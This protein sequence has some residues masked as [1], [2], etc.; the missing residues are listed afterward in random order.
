[1][2]ETTGLDDDAP[3]PEERYAGF[4]IRALALLI[5]TALVWSIT[6]PILLTVHGQAYWES[7]SFFYSPLDFLLSWVLPTIVEITFWH[8]R[9]ASPGKM[10]VGVRI[11]DA[12]AGG[13]LTLAQCVGRYFAMYLS[14][15][16]LGMGFL[17]IGADARRQ[18]WHDM[19]AGT[20]VVRRPR[21]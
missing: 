6:I 1:M 7:D 4:W 14:L 10:I 18:G 5:D 3:L 19:L 12:K 9:G 13:P 21:E 2:D 8:I 17:W 15:L 16:P 20:L 11:I